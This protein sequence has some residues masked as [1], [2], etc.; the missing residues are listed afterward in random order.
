MDPITA[1]GVASATVNLLD[2]GLNLSKALM[3]SIRAWRNAPDEILELNNRVAFLSVALERIRDT[4]G[5]MKE[6]G[7]PNPNYDAV[8]LLE[9]QL[10]QAATSLEKLSGYVV[11]LSSGSRTMQRT[12]WIRLKSAVVDETRRIREVQGN[13]D[14]VLVT[15]VAY[16]SR[17]FENPG[18]EADSKQGYGDAHSPKYPPLWKHPPREP[19][20]ITARYSRAGCFKGC[21]CQCH[22]SSSARTRFHATSPLGGLLGGISVGYSG[23]G[24]RAQCD[25]IG[26]WHRGRS[27]VEVTYIF[28]SW[29][30]CYTLYMSMY[31]TA[32][33]RPTFGLVLRRRVK[34]KTGTTLYVSLLSNMPLLKECLE[35]DPA[36][37][38]DAFYVD[39][40]SALESAVAYGRVNVARMLLSYGA[41]PDAESDNG[42][43]PGIQAA[44]SVLS[45]AVSK[46]INDQW[47][48]LF[49]IPRY[50]D[51]LELPLVTQ[52]VTE[53]RSGDLESLLT[54]TDLERQLNERDRAGLTPLFWASRSGNVAATKKLLALGADINA[55]TR[56]K[57]TPLMAAVS[58]DKMSPCFEV[59]LRAGADPYAR[60]LIGKTVLHMAC[61]KGH[62]AAVRALLRLG[63]DPDDG[64]TSGTGLGYAPIRDSVDVMRAL[65]EH[66]AN[67]NQ[68]TI[69]GYTPLVSATSRNAHR[70]IRFLLESGA[71]HLHVVDSEGTTLLHNAALGGNVRTMEILAEHGL[72]GLDVGKKNKDGLTAWQCLENRSDITPKL[73]EAFGRL[74]EAILAAGVDVGPDLGLQG[75]E[76]EE[77]DD[78]DDPFFDA[79]EYQED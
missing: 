38:T 50:I 1:L 33:G 14:N 71:N 24:T 46:E 58:T 42:M 57:K 67:V 64:G 68:G 34:N 41:S 23:Y 51:E 19:V 17:Q 53:Q 52:I 36:S 10:A 54:R 55:P 43:T 63:M 70:C 12:R 28:P 2:G 20:A 49:D 76:G 4:Y 9:H 16:V 73:R 7:Q 74:L 44:V 37:V 29:L 77:D 27:H 72:P 66:G 61:A 13:I 30:V 15:Y 39:G 78:A 79:P 48:R 69:E 25:M 11:Q 60:D 45:K 8:F 40:V 56:G 3:K 5:S 21:L 47:Y 65:V 35:R 75:N 22:R 32:M 6:P 62:A 59:L 18:G 31:K 26:C